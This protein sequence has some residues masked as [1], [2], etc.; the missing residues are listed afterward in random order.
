VLSKLIRM[1]ALTSVCVVLL[2]WAA[3]SPLSVR[4]AER[5]AAARAGTSADLTQIVREAK[6]QFHPVGERDVAEARKSLEKSLVALE[7]ILG[8]PA[9]AQQWKD[10]LGWR[11]IE[12]QLAPGRSPDPEQ[13][14]RVRQ[15]FVG[16]Y[17]GLEM[18]RFT[19]V[20]T[21]LGKYAQALEDAAN[22]TL[23]RDFELHLDA[24]ADAVQ[25]YLAAPD[26]KLADRIAADLG[27]LECRSQADSAVAAVRRRLSHPNVLIYMPESMLAASFRRHID[28]TGPVQDVILGTQIYGTGRTTGSLSPAL[29]PRDDQAAVRIEMTAV[30]VANTVGYNGPVQVYQHNRAELYG[31]KRIVLDRDGLRTL[32][33]ES[34]AAIE[35]QVTGLEASCRCY[36]IRGMVRRK[37]YRRVYCQKAQA[38]RIAEDHQ[39]QRLNEQL[40]RDVDARLAESNAELKEK[41]FHPLA[42]HDIVPRQLATR[43]HGNQLLVLA[44]LATADQLGAANRPPPPTRGTDLVLQVHESLAENYSAA[45]L[46][47]KTYTAEQ[48]AALIERVTQ[49]SSDAGGRNANGE[50]VTIT[51]DDVKPVTL[52]IEAG[53]AAL[54]LHGRQY[55]ARNQGYPPMDVTVRYRLEQVDG[56]LRLT[57]AD[58]LKI[59]PPRFRGDGPHQLSLREATLRRLLENQL[60]RQL[61]PQ[62]FYD[63]ITLEGQL[64]ALGKLNIV[65]SVAENGWLTLKCR[66][67]QPANH[68]SG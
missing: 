32:P 33:A 41:V 8:A 56:G 57:R 54:T 67:E 37:A 51:L 53:T 61:P 30:N 26:R 9:V 10:F 28:E 46:G 1:K 66:Q 58:E 22:P 31:Q 64:S 60:Q 21:A 47:G 7:R 63:G 5:V 18:R 40:D 44:E 23:R 62:L 42:R 29:A 11:T 34:S 25:S 43:T 49:E 4:A 59:V 65:Q 14:R 38:D 3:T 27:W 36:L 35:S 16:D 19:D 15:R 45:A 52:R 12:E 39:R 17:A 50:N 20:R 2:I 55:V 24:L 48:L 6:A 68:S 13:L